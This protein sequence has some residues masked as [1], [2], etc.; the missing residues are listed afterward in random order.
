M[1][2]AKRTEKFCE[3]IGYVTYDINS[4]KDEM[5]KLLTVVLRILPY[6]QSSGI[7]LNVH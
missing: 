7:Y 4:I 3:L 2:K 6:T 5:M 1:S